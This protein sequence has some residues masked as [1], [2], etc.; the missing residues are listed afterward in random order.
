MSELHILNPSQARFLA[1]PGVNIHHYSMAGLFKSK[2][3]LDAKALAEAVAKTFE[4]NQALNLCIKKEKN[5]YRQLIKAFDPRAE[6]LNIYEIDAENQSFVMKV[7]NDIIKNMDLFSGPLARFCLF[8]LNNAKY[9]LF[10][11][12]VHHMVADGVSIIS[13]MQDIS[14]AYQCIKKGE[15]VR[16]NQEG[17]DYI[18]YMD[19]IQ[20]MTQSHSVRN[21]ISYWQK[22]KNKDSQFP[23]DTDNEVNR[24][25][26][27]ETRRFQIISAEH[28]KE[29]TKHIATTQFKLSSLVLTSLLITAHQISGQNKLLVDVVNNGRL[30]LDRK[31]NL[32]RTVGWLSTITPLLLTVGD[33]KNKYKVMQHVRSQL[34]ETPNQGMNFHVLRYLLQEGESLAKNCKTNILFN[35]C[36]EM[37]QQQSGGEIFELLVSDKEWLDLQHDMNNRADYPLHIDIFHTEKGIE[38]VFDFGR[39][40]FKQTSIDKV[41]E[42]VKQNALSIINS[43]DK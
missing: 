2:I 26:E 6:Y 23:M 10:F 22:I 28:L 29:M 14:Q 16:F 30:F 42:L 36:G 13:I 15:K 35:Y 32:N 7:Y 5:G 20:E 21:E 12:A 25:Y 19:L 40:S 33:E 27:V 8:K 9:D 17:M 43:G 3:K 24:R 37:P 4:K 31:I 1:L 18:E 34:L 41:V 11:I 39:N 38:G